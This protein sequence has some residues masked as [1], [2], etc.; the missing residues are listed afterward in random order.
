MENNP[1]IKE[2][3]NKATI[4]ASYRESLLFGIWDIFYPAKRDL[5]IDKLKQGMDWQYA[6]NEAKKYDNGKKNS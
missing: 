3:L 1:E 5:I 4:H 2:L 6:F